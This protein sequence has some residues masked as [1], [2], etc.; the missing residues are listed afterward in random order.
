MNKPLATLSLALGLLGIGAGAARADTGQILQP[1][2]PDCAQGWTS[3]SYLAC[4][5]SFR[6]NLGGTLSADQLATLDA[7]FGSLGFSSAAASSYS[8]TDLADHGLF[9]DD[10]RDF[11]LD[12]DAGLRATGLFVIGLKQADRYSFY[13][14]DGGTAGVSGLSFDVAGVVP[15]NK[16][17]LSHA[18]YLGAAL[19]PAATPVP[20][21]DAS[22]LLAAGLAALAFVSWRRPRP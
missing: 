8:K 12:F 1:G 17:G 7:A 19:V 16:S 9:A 20:E 15:L 22:T 2:T 13:L 18:A 6:G 3:L 14:F 21:P 5:G 4:A 11:S 10:G